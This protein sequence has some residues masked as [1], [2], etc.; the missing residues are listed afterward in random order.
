MSFSASSRY[1]NWPSLTILPRIGITYLWPGLR[2]LGSDGTPNPLSTEWLK[3]FAQ[4]PMVM[5]ALLYGAAVH[6]DILRS[7]I[8]GLPKSRHLYYKGETIRL[9]KEELKTSEGSALDD[10]ILTTLCLSAN[11]VETARNCMIEKS[12]RSPFR[13]PLARAQWLDVYGMMSHVSAHVA[14]LRSLVTLRGGLDK[15]ELEG[16]AEVLSL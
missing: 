1:G 12:N 8:M 6:L 10:M 5:F 14:A 3:R 4:R 16:L 7:P 11:E 2:P 9:L 13:S 15:I